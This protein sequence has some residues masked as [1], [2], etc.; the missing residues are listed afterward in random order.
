MS[1]EQTADKK[2]TRRPRGRPPRS[3]TAKTGAER[4]A[5]YRRRRQRLICLEMDFKLFGE[6]IKIVREVA[7]NPTKDGPDA[8]MA[9]LLL[10]RLISSYQAKVPWS[11]VPG[12]YYEYDS[13][14]QSEY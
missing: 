5:A 4:Q 6:L 2:A 13:D 1:D 7:D 3:G 12:D 10:P 11:E 8:H 9:E 14:Y